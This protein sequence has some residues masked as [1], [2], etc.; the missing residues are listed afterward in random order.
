MML[1]MMFDIWVSVLFSRMGTL[2]EIRHGLLENP[3][4]SLMMFPANE[5]A[6]ASSDIFAA[7]HVGF[8]DCSTITS[9]AN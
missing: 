3:P 5:S 9:T 1:N 6:M 4:Y 2:R 7:K 8:P